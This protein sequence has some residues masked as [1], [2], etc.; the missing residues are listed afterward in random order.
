MIRLRAEI[1]RA[2][3]YRITGI[4]F[5][6]P[7]ISQKMWF[8][9]FMRIGFRLAFVMVSATAI[10]ITATDTKSSGVGV[11]IILVTTVT[12]ILSVMHFYN[13][14]VLLH[15]PPSN[16]KEEMEARRMNEE[17]RKENI[18]NE[19]HESDSVKELFADIILHLY[20]FMLYAAFWEYINEFG[21]N[22]IH[23]SFR[24]S[25][26]AF[27]AGVS[28]FMMLA[29]MVAVGLVPM[30]LAYWIEE[31]VNAITL[32]EKRSMWGY[33]ILAILLTCAPSIM[34]FINIYF[35]K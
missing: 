21:I 23:R 26:N 27:S 31:S 33:F 25:E 15:N 6:A 32:K 19:L 10:G 12:E 1:K 2:E 17:W 5:G 29:A 14:S 24:A 11:I 7:H 22:M 3:H 35:K 34:E 13:N 8:P 9:L 28:V 16:P 4:Y 20:A 30:R 18:A